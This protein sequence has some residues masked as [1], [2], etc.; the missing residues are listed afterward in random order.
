MLLLGIPLE[1]VLPPSGKFGLYVRL[2]GAARMVMRIAHGSE[3]MAERA[4]VF[5]DF[6]GDTPFREVIVPPENVA[7]SSADAAPTEI[8]FVAAPG[9]REPGLTYVQIDCILPILTR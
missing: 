1:G 7:W 8:H 6:Q 3:T 5:S 4:V 9:E 2:R